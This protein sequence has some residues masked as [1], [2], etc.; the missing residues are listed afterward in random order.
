MCIRDL[1]GK[2]VL[3][4]GA[5]SGIGRATALAFSREGAHLVLCD[6]DAASLALDALRRAASLDRSAVRAAAFATH[7]F[8]GALGRYSI[9]PNGETSC[10]RMSGRQVRDGSFDDERAVLLTLACGG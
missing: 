4:T 1:R 2:R 8:D 10:T 5:A 6:L 3:V 7:D 9:D